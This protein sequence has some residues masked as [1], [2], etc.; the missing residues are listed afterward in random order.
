MGTALVYADGQF[1][2]SRPIRDSFAIVKA[3]KSLAGQIVDV[4]PIE[5]RFRARTDFLGPAVVPDL[6]SYQYRKIT[7]E[8]QN[9]PVGYESGQQ[10]FTALATYKSGS[11]TSAATE[12]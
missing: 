5:Q 3:E 9:L 1:A 7:V 12:P 2:V 4:D 10:N 8:P 6:Q 11:S